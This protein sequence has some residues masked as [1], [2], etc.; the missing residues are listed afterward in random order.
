MQDFINSYQDAIINA[1]I[2]TPL[3]PSVKMAQCI[4]ETGWGKRIVGNNLF[5]I[6]GRG[7]K[8]PYWDGS[9]IYANT[10]EY[11][12]GSAGIY[13]EPF[14][15]YKTQEDSVKDHNHL[16]LTLSRYQDVRQAK[17]PEE[18]ANALQKNGYATD[19]NYASK[20][21]NLINRYNLKTLDQ[22]K[23]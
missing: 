20:L 6:K 11:T 22:K 3:F 14:R 19:P 8:T 17:T 7:Y 16:L 9:V 1:C 12:N 15:N 10:Q 4:L 5:G 18:Q 13:N 23:K 2:G 21:I